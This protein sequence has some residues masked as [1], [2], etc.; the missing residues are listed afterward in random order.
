MKQRNRKKE[1]LNIVHMGDFIDELIRG[2][3]TGWFAW[4]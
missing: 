2:R 1:N 3:G 4:I